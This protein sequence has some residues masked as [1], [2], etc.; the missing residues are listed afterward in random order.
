[1]VYPG[2]EENFT[3]NGAADPATQAKVIADMEDFIAKTFP[4]MPA[5]EEEKA[6]APKARKKR[7]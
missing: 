5:A 3:R 1:V 7:K 4:P 2:V 6:P